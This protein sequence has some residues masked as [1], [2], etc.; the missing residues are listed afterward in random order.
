[1]GNNIMERS[2][3]G[4]TKLDEGEKH[5]LLNENKVEVELIPEKGLVIKHVEYL[6]TSAKHQSQVERRY[7]DF[8]AMHELLVLRYRCRLIPKLPPK[9]I[10]SMIVGVKSGLV[11]ERR[12]A[13]KRWLLILLNHPIVSLDPVV[14]DFFCY[15]GL[16]CGNHMKTQYSSLPDEY[17]T[18][19]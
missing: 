17:I 5:R 6:V 1:M 4:V 15:T 7:S 13:L 19:T 2:W 14:Q 16:D 3:D 8:A 11:G 12:R 9:N 10:G 18:G